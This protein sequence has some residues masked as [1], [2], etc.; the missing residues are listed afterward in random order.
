MVEKPCS[1]HLSHAYEMQDCY[2]GYLQLHSPA[3]QYIKNHIGDIGDPQ[4][5]RSTRASM[6]PR[7]R[8]DLSI[9][10]DYMVHD[11]YLFMDR[12]NQTAA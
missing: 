8:T 11:I 6:G 9:V 1:I 7:V 12:L 2:P 3:Y 4:L 10:E 5:Y